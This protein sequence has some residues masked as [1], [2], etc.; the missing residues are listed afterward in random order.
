MAK[1]KRITRVR[2]VFSRV[3][4]R[5]KKMTFPVAVIAGLIPGVAGTMEAAKGGWKAGGTYA[6]SA[7]TG[8]NPILGTFSIGNMSQGLK[9]LAIGVV[10]HKVAGWLGI[11]KAIAGAGIPFIRI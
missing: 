4:R 11:N 5:A 9:P 7:Y 1:K 3:S 8:Y 10:I 2:R 6:C